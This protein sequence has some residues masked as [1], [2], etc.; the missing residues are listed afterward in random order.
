M[1]KKITIIA[2]FT[3][4]GKHTC[5][6]NFKK[7]QI[8]PFLGSKHFGCEYICMHSRCQPKL[9]FIDWDFK[10]YIEPNKNECIFYNK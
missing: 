8:C 6:G 2:Y 10:G 5:A 3:P 9:H 7:K 1:K 4:E